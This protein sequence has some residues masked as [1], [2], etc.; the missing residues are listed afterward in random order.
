MVVS[1]QF[2][3]AGMGISMFRSQENQHGYE[4]LFSSLQRGPYCR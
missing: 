2:F 1:P 3:G 4:V